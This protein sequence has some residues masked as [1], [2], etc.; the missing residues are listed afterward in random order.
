M[1]KFEFN[2][3]QYGVLLRSLE[4]REQKVL[5]VLQ[6]FPDNIIINETYQ[7]ELT[8]I[9]DLIENLINVTL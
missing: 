9:R 3:T 1:F 6:E 8:E 2:Y 5:S 7:N 4:T